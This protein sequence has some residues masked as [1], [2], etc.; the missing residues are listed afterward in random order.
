[1]CRI[2]IVASSTFLYILV[3][4][5]GASSYPYEREREWSRSRCRACSGGT[6]RERGS[7]P[8]VSRK[9]TFGSPGFS[10]SPTLASLGGA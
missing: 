4:R 6:D 7:L 1:M 8:Q 2:K 3:K 5:E 9:H 10:S